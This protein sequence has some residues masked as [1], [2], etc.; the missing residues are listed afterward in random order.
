MATRLSTA[1]TAGLIALVATT[2]LAQDYPGREQ[3]RGQSAEFRREVI[4]VASGVYVAVGYSASNVVLIQGADSS[5][6][7]SAELSS[8]AERQH[9]LVGQFK[10]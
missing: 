3:L 4:Q 2:A 1:A 8:L 6:R 10:I 5:A 9:A 7:L